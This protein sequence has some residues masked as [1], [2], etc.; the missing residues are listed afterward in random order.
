MDG[1]APPPL[2]AGAAP[3]AQA[4]APVTR[5]TV[6]NGDLS[7]A[8]FPVVVGHFLGDSIAG[9]ESQL[10]YAL[11]GALTRRYALGVYP[12][13]VGS[14][15]VVGPP[16]ASG[17]AAVA[18]GIGDIGSFSPGV[19]R[20]A[21]IAGLIELAL[22]PCWA[23]PERGVSLVMLG[24][25]AGTVSA[26]DTLAAML[27]AIGEVQRRLLEQ[28]LQPL[29]EVHFFALYEDD[30]H[31]IW[32]TL[33][34]FV[35]SPHY[36]DT[37]TLEREVAYAAGAQRRLMRMEDPNLWR[38]IQIVS[39]DAAGGDLGFRFTAVGEQARADGYLVGANRSF[40][41]EFLE[42]AQQRKL[43]AA[44][45]RALFQLVWPAELKQ[46]SQ[47]DRNLRLILDEAAAALPFELM[48]DRAAPVAGEGEGDS[49]PPAIRRGMIRQLIQT[50]FAR[51]QT[52][53]HGGERALVIGDPRGG[54]PAE[55]FPALPGAREEAEAVAALLEEQGFEVVRL[56]GDDVTPDAVVEHVLQGGWTILH[57]SAHG[58]YDYAFR[59]DR[60]VATAA[61]WD[62][63]AGHYTGPRYTGVVLGD[64]LTLAPSI[65]QSMPDPPVLAFIN[66][67]DLASIDPDD[68][69]ALRAAAR[70]EFAA[71]FAGELIA[72]GGRAVIAAGWEV[73]D[74]GA[75]V[76]AQSVYREL[77][78]NNQ[79]FG[80]A[81]RIAR[82]DVYDQDRDDATWGAYQCYGEPDWRLRPDSEMPPKKPPQPCFASPA[83][84]VAAI[85]GIRNQA[86]VGAGRDSRRGALVAQLTAIEQYVR[87]LAWLARDQVS[88]Q[89]GHAYLALGEAKQALG[90]FEEA[91]KQDAAPSLRLVEALAN[92]RIR[93]AADGDDDSGPSPDTLARI[94]AAR[95]QLVLLCEVAGKTGERL[96]L[97][98]EAATREAHLLTGDARDAALAQ[99]REA[100]EQAWALSRARQAADSYYPGLMAVTAGV[101]IALRAGADFTACRAEIEDL[102]ADFARRTGP[103][104]YGRTVS[105]AGKHLLTALVDGQMSTHNAGAIGGALRQ[106]WAIS[107]NDVDRNTVIGHLR[108]LQAIL[109][110]KDAARAAADWVA[111]IEQA[112][113]LASPDAALI[114][115]EPAESPAPA[116]TPA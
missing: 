79:G 86:E 65:L 72:L 103:G 85:E 14:A 76:F 8:R 28:G 48:D 16:D 24:T 15:M 84:A 89:L 110:E 59:S 39:A 75:L 32:H 44:P 47:E 91:L 34:R 67:C 7:F 52:S 74:H 10:D 66:C 27:A 35:D 49:A 95:Q 113:T 73:S 83:E 1:P 98:G 6:V 112:A 12:G 41:K 60:A 21:L 17:M 71:S 101:L 13:A 20:S 80:E 57:V 3:A 42:V 2:E 29:G 69:A 51:L 4:A 63:V 107:G 54:S 53:P 81:V 109:A 61:G 38:V 97:I 64:R 55:D 56:I 111:S 115:V 18:V 19:I 46:T 70:P 77:L 45:T 36:R 99:M 9:A 93:Q 26:S 5:L 82:G 25:R 87:G 22:S 11:G 43:N 114:K 37:F 106:A 92:L 90:L 33:R 105:L 23:A 116:A 100:F 40:V 108:F 58:I 62:G 104:D 94:A 31:R 30:A 68:E 88:E 78:A 50:R 96:S 102:G